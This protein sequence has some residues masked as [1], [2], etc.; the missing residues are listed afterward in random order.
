[1]VPKNQRF[2]GSVSIMSNSNYAKK[3]TLAK[4]APLVVT[5]FRGHANWLGGQGA[6]RCRRAQIAGVLLLLRHGTERNTHVR[7]P[8]CQPWLTSYAGRA[9]G[10]CA[11]SRKVRGLPASSIP[12]STRVGFE[13]RLTS[14]S[15]LF[16]RGS[17]QKSEWSLIAIASRPGHCVTTGPLSPSSYG[18][19]TLICEVPRTLTFGGIWRQWEPLVGLLSRRHPRRGRLPVLPEQLRARVETRLSA[20]P[21]AV[22]DLGLSRGSGR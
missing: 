8:A 18:R 14:D 12:L 19:P 9:S 10:R 4:H 22:S 15:C 20:F 21:S 5:P 2:S 3:A 6:V 13:P 7:I 11:P 17:Q 16:F 1:M